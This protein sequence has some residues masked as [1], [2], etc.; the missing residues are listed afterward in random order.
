MPAELLAT[1]RML[2]AADDFRSGADCALAAQ[3]RA[4]GGDQ[5]FQHGGTINRLGW[6]A[7]RNAACPGR[8]SQSAGSPSCLKSMASG[9]NRR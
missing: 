1:Q 9:N 4:K 5:L 8:W 2:V 6:I 7:S 3:G